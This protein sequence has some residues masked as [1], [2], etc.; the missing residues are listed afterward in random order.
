MYFT[1]NSVFQHFM[2]EF[3]LYDSHSHD[4]RLLSQEY[5]FDIFLNDTSKPSIHP[6]KSMPILPLDPPD[7]LL[8]LFQS[9]SSR[10]H[11]FPNSP[12]FPIVWHT[13]MEIPI[14][15]RKGSFLFSTAAHIVYFCTACILTCMLAPQIYLA[16][17]QKKLHTLVTAM[18]LQRLPI[19]EAMSAF[20]IP[21]NE[22]AKLICQDPWV[23]IAVTLITILGEAVYLYR[24]CSKMTFFK[25]YLYDNTCTIYLF[26]SHECYYIPVKLRE[27]NGL[28]HIFALSGQLKAQNL[29]LL[30]HTLWDTLHIKWLSTTLNMNGKRINLPENVNIPLWDKVKVRSIMANK[31]VKFNTM[32]KQGNTWY[33]PKIEVANVRPLTQEEVSADFNANQ[34]S[35]QDKDKQDTL[36]Q[37][38]EDDLSKAPWQKESTKGP[39]EDL[40]KITKAVKPIYD[41]FWCDKDEDIINRLN[42]AAKR[43]K[44]KRAAQLQDNKEDYTAIP[45]TSNLERS[46]SLCNEPIGHHVLQCT[47]ETLQDTLKD[48]TH[49]TPVEPLTGPPKI[50]HPFSE[51]SPQTLLPLP[52]E[53][54]PTSQLS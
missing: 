9:I 44:E 5:I 49:S 7:T 3:G 50:V 39:L 8:E 37:A 36:A 6:N 22:E 34:D 27:L 19:T 12:Y 30:K 41:G 48:V 53:F 16:C 33:A 52:Q 21:Q 45:A 13:S 40:E 23:S 25:G 15:P 42:Q 2:S 47:K 32:I 18:T 29:Q 54:Q 4:G 10:P 24:A 35:F 1:V 46:C 38:L 51:I 31:S 26:L 43:L 11:T 14:Y 28:L 20:K 17:K